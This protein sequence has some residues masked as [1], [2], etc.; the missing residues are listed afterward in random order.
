MLID[1]LGSVCVK[2]VGI[3]KVLG[4]GTWEI[5]IRVKCIWGGSLSKPNLER[6][7]IVRIFKWGSQI[8]YPWFNSEFDEVWQICKTT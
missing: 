5:D 6:S 1:V 2:I 3:N 8:W 4:V 7:E